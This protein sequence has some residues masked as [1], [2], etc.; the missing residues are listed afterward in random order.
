[1]RGKVSDQDLTNYALNELPPSERLYVESMLGVSEECRGD[2]YQ[3]LELGEMLKEGFEADEAGVDLLLNDEQRTKVLTVPRWD[4]RGFL[5]QAAAITLLAAGTAFA[6]TRPGFWQKG[7]V[8][9]QLS[10]ATDKLTKFAQDI[11]ENGL[12]G[13][14]RTPE[15]YN[16]WREARA[17]EQIEWQ[18]AQAGVVPAVCTPTPEGDVPPM[19]DMGEM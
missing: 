4:W 15:E 14:A 18:F 12:S 11:S 1:M 8:G 13:F 2:V 9:G 6:M 16:R 3:M 5:R 17:S 10:E 7:G 19:P